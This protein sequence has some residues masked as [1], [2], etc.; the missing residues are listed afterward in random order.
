MIMECFLLINICY[1]LGLER[2]GQVDE[3]QDSIEVRIRK[4]GTTTM[5]TWVL[6]ITN[7]HFVQA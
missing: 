6:F 3:W 2:H 1:K 5:A 7:L 4:L